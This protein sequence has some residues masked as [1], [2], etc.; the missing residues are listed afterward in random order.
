MNEEQRRVQ[1]H[2]RKRDVVFH[3]ALLP[4]EAAALPAKPPQVRGALHQAKAVWQRVE[5]EDYRQK[6]WVR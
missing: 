2:E 5:Q 1:C 3:A 4:L 6:I